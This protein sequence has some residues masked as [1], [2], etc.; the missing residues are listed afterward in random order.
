MKAFKNRSFDQSEGIQRHVIWSRMLIILSSGIQEQ[1]IRSICRHSKTCYSIFWRSNAVQ[2]EALKGLNRKKWWRWKDTQN[3]S[4]NERLMH[5]LTDQ[6][7]RRETKSARRQCCKN[8]FV[9][10]SSISLKGKIV[11]VTTHASMHQICIER[12]GKSIDVNLSLW[13]CDS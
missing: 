2:C 4:K 13:K 11:T 10:T 3:H 8:Y 9:K 7:I 1:V 6:L 12:Q 5:W